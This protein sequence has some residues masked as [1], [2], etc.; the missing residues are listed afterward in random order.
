MKPLL[1]SFMIVLSTNAALADAELS[2]AQHQKLIDILVTA[3]N[4]R[5]TWTSVHAGEALISVGEARIVLASFAPQTQSAAPPFR[6]GVWRVLARCTATSPERQGYVERIRAVALDGEATDRT[7]AIEALAKL[8]SPM[9]DD[10]ER[11]AMREIARGSSDAAPFAAW[12]MACVDRDEGTGRLIEMLR[13]GDP[14][15]RSARRTRSH[16][17]NRTAMPRGRH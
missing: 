8:E 14:A 9:L 12:R 10:S 16:T 17:F 1:A 7:H 2:P 11:R 5:G 4:Q 3:M 6:I 15:I 13:S